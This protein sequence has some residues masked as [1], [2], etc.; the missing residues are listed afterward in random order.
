MGEGPTDYWNKWEMTVQDFNRAVNNAN[1]YSSIFGYIAQERFIQR[2]LEG[3]A[4]ITVV[5]SPRDHDRRDQG[6]YIINYG[7]EELRLEVKS[8]KADT[9]VRPSNETLDGD[10]ERLKAKFQI[11]ASDRS[12]VYEYDGE[13]Y[14]T[15]LYSIE[16]FTPDIIAVNMY[17][18][19]EEW[20]FGFVRPED[21]PRTPAKK[22]PEG[23]REK[24]MKSQPEITKPLR[25]P[26]RDNLYVLLDEIIEER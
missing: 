18:F 7:G 20:E 14:Q 24:L 22:F 11:F 19:D 23:L 25:E 21:L 2:W 8:L 6:D 26:Y 13:E 5:T 9:I 12:K 16:D 10:E 1:C 17:R 4:K 3:H 15:V